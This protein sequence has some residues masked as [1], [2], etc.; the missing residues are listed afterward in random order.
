MNR[1]E[2]LRELRGKGFTTYV[3]RSTMFGHLTTRAS[4]RRVRRTTL[5]EV[6]LSTGPKGTV[7]LHYQV[8]NA[9]HYLGPSGLTYRVHEEETYA[10]AFDAD[11]SQVKRFLARI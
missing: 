7:V 2:I 1:T 8:L 3:E 9:H 5:D 6:C 11:L 10:P 4:A